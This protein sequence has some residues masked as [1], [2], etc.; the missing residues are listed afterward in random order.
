MFADI[1]KAAGGVARTPQKGFFLSDLAGCEGPVTGLLAVAACEKRETKAGKPY[2]S[3]TLSDR[4]GQIEARD[5]DH[6]SEHESVFER[7]VV[8][9]VRAIV[10]VYNGKQQLKIEKARRWDE[11]YD[12]GDFVPASAY[13]VEELVAAL[14]SVVEGLENEWIRKLL[15]TALCR[16]RDEWLRTPAAMRIHHAWAGGLAEHVLSMCRAALALTTH[17]TRVN[18]D[19]LIAG[20]ILHDIGK[21]REIDV[22]ITLAHSILG[23]LVG[24]IAEGLI[25]LEDCCRSIEGFPDEIKMRIRHMIVSHHGRMEYGALKQPMTPEAI[26]LSALDDLDF[27]LECTFRLIDNANGADFSPYQHSLER[28][29]YC[30]EPE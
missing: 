18:R 13:N 1:S 11:A 12:V 14:G 21:M 6:A 5:W 28:E 3:L 26:V 30:K 15:Q 17:Y 4:T 19:L 9:K 22:G 8:V 10:E 25:I 23:K 20:C 29:I 27:K 7:G 24:H 16:H 2:L